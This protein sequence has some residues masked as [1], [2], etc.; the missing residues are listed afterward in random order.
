[1]AKK[2]ST[3]VRLASQEI[4]RFLETVPP[5]ERERRIN[6]AHALATRSSHGSHATTA[7]SAETRAIRLVAQSPEE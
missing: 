1:M 6:A 3:F 5:K 4:E 2:T 7:R